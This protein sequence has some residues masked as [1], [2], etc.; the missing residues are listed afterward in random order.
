MNYSSKDQPYPRGEICF[1][2]PNVFLGYYKNEEKTKVCFY[3][4][5][6]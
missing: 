2:G 4:H 6:K 1:R 3:N 5:L